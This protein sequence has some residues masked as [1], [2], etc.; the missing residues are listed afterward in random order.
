MTMAVAV[1]IASG[2]D[3]RRQVSTRNCQEMEERR[4]VVMALVDSNLQRRY[5]SRSKEMSLRTV[6]SLPPKLPAITT[7]EGS[8]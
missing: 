2:E 6:R 5:H 4:K 8:L 1:L 3:M 7:V